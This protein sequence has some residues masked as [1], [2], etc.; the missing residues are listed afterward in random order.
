MPMQWARKR[1]ARPVI[2]NTPAFGVSPP[3]LETF[4][5]SGATP[6]LFDL[7]GNRLATAEIRAKP[8]IVA[9]GWRRYDVLRL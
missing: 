3:V 7:A 8:E 1:W 5:S 6:I 9:P 4:S 2:P